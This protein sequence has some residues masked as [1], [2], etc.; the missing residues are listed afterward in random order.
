MNGMAAMRLG[1][2]TD[3]CDQCHGRRVCL[4]GVFPD[5]EG[6]PGRGA[7]LCMKCL[8]ALVKR[9]EAK[10]LALRANTEHRTSNTEHRTGNPELGTGR[11]EG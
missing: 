4:A 8:N 5:A 9:P 6:E 10:P 7:G 1:G 2:Q 11:I 3:T